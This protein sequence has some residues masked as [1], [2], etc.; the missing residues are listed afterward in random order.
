MSEMVEKVALAMWADRDAG[1]ASI[2]AAYGSGGAVRRPRFEDES[3][4]WRS[5]AR[6]AIAAM[7]EPT[8]QLVS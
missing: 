1:L 5:Q 3:E 4:I 7:R 2:E 6:A 8:K